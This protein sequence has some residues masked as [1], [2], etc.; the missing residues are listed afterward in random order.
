MTPP[1]H[2]IA[3]PAPFLP[4]PPAIW[5]AWWFWLA[6][7]AG[8]ALLALGIG[9]ARRKKSASLREQTLMDDARKRLAAIKATSGSI[10]P[11]SAATRIS[12][13]LR[14]YLEAAYD[15]PA[16][17]ETNEE[18]ILR[19]HSLAKIHR[20]SRKPVTEHLE[21]LCELKYFP[22]SDKAQITSLIDRT[23]DLLLSIGQNTEG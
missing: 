16:L 18:F 14:Q 20:D 5:L 17:F 15:D 19:P 4:G 7:V 6:L 2:D 11:E 22:G 3:D 12:L 10:S 8:I 21:Q 9:Y 1:I 13:V 23:D